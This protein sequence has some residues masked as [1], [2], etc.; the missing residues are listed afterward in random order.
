MR[1][2][3]TK[4]QR[5]KQCITNSMQQD[6]RVTMTH[7]ALVMWNIYTPDP[8]I[9]SFLQLVKINTRSKAIRHN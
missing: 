7:R 9:P 8:K 3:I 5:T 2:D 4:G 6:I 1:P